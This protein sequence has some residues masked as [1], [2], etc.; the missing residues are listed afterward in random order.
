MLRRRRFGLLPLA[1]LTL[2]LIA[3]IGQGT[4]SSARS[5]RCRR[6]PLRHPRRFSSPRTACVRTSSKVRR[7]RRHADVREPARH[8]RQ[9]LRNGPAPRLP[10]QHGRRLDDARHGTWPSEHGSTNNTFHRTGEGN[11]NNSTSF[12]AADRPGGPHR[13]G[14]RARGQ[15]RGLDGMGCIGS[16][17][18][19][20]GP[21]VDFRSF[22]GGRGDRPQLRHP[23]QTAAAFGV[24]YQRLGAPRAAQ[25]RSRTRPAG[26]GAGLPQHREERPSP[27]TTRVS[28][29][30]ASGTCT[31]T[32]PPT[33]AR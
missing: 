21:V 22:F 13:A 29:A 31:S 10:A 30:V 28:R 33:T 23:G 5:R 14:G 26:L 6:R 27:K 2:V 17:T 3:S 4:A 8:R 25:L 1:A 32:T 9:G 24:Q 20:Q 15:V 12:A 18:P 19:L 11:F 16:L 7:R